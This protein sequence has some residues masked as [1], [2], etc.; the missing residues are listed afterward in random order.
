MERRTK[1]EPFKVLQHPRFRAAYDLLLL[2][3]SASSDDSDIGKW[4][5]KFQA[6]SRKTKILMLDDLKKNKSEVKKFGFSGELG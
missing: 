6:S 1:F 4:W 5:T 2:R 3:E